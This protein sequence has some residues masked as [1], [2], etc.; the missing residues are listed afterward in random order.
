MK[1]FDVVWHGSELV[2]ILSDEMDVP[3]FNDHVGSSACNDEFDPTDPKQW[4]S[5]KGHLGYDLIGDDYTIAN[6]I[7]CRKYDPNLDAYIAYDNV[8]G[9]LRN[10][11][12]LLS[13]VSGSGK[14]TLG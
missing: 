14:V 12:G 1:K 7:N 5:F 10:L 2:V 4:D 11:N 3:F 13:L 6:S 9:K 8:S